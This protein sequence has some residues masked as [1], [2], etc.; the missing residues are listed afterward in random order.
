MMKEENAY[1]GSSFA[2]VFLKDFFWQIF[3]ERNF[4]L[5]AKLLKHEMS[6]RFVKSHG[7][8][9]YIEIKVKVGDKRYKGIRINAQSIE[10]ITGKRPIRSLETI[11]RLA[12]WSV[13]EL[14]FKMKSG[15][16]NG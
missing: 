9:I 1:T 4:E 16:A 8:I 15:D 14:E 3:E 5:M 10:G 13:Q 12:F 7:D 11:K 2:T 6:I